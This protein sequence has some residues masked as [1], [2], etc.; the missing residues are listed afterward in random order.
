[1]A[2]LN[3]LID[4]L[5]KGDYYSRASAARALGELGGEEAAAALI[6]ALNDEDD[7]VQE[8]AA[9]ALGKLAHRPAV[10]P[11]SKLL[12]S[13]S[14]KVRCTTV[15][16]LGKIGGDEALA[17]L[18]PLREDSDSWVRDAAVLA[19]ENIAATPAPTTPPQAARPVVA[20][21]PI[22]AAIEPVLSLSEAPIDPAELAAAAKHRLAD[23]TPRTPEEI[24][25]LL[26]QGESARY[27]AT[28]SGFLLRIDVGGG[29]RQRVRLAFDSVDEDDSP[30]I[31]IFS[32]IGPARAKHHEWALKLNPSFSYGAIGIVK[33]DGKDALAVFDTFLEENVDVKALK[34]S[35]WTLAKR[36]DALEKKL[37]RKDLW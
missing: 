28:R 36:A 11:L 26:T 12:G 33:I 16:T 22:P 27:K 1:M 18:E 3:T 8:Y 30:I 4:N 9:E 20:S 6:G 31:Q 19:L 37:I 17:L 14:Y 7:W 32:V 29:R 21:E 15:A 5:G 10:E 34:K 35:V 2:D 23:N 13:E 25:Q 24:V